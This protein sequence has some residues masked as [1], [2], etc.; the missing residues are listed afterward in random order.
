MTFRARNRKM[1]SSLHRLRFQPNFTA[2]ISTILSCAHRQHVSL[3]CTKWSPE[4]NI[5]KSCPPF[6][7]QTA[8]WISITFYRSDQYYPLLWTLPERFASLHKMATRAK[9]RKIF[10]GKTADGISTNLHMSYQY[11]P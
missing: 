7:G 8:G 11:H 5:E 9:N 1:L 4:L 10:T 2:V 3:C 6:T